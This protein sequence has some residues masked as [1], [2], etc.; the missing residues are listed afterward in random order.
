M[1]RLA[2]CPQWNADFEKEEKW[3]QLKFQWLKFQW[4]RALIPG[5]LLGGAV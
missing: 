3:S 4:P 2:S 5:Q 1:G